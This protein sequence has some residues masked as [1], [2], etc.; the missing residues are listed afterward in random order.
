MCGRTYIVIFSEVGVGN[1]L[2]RQPDL[3]IFVL[4]LSTVCR[5]LKMKLQ[6]DKNERGR[7]CRF[8][9]YLQ[10]LFLNGY[11]EMYICL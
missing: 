5:H 8:L 9:R 4:E 11:V 2:Y 1:T 7:Y 10:M 3:L 6:S